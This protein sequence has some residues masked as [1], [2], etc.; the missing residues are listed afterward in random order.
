MAA[1]PNEHDLATAF[2]EQSLRA[3]TALFA[4]LYAL[5]T[6][7]GV[8]QVLN[9]TERGA[10]AVPLTVFLLSGA[11]AV[12]ARRDYVDLARL[13]FLSTLLLHLLVGNLISPMFQRLAFGFPLTILTVF[14]S[15]LTCP[16]WMAKRANLMAI[17]A[18]PVGYLLALAQGQDFGG[19]PAD[20]GAAIIGQTLIL[21]FSDFALARLSGGWTAALLDADIARSKIAAAHR[22]ALD[23]SRAKTTFLA[24]MSHELR[25]PLNAVIGYA[26]LVTDDLEDTGEADVRDLGRITVAARHL[27]ELVN[28]VLDLSR[29]EAGK[30]SLELKQ[31]D[32]SDLARQVCETLQPAVN[33]A[34]NRLVPRF[35]TVS[36]L[37]LDPLRTR[38]I[39][40]NLLGNATKFTKNGVIEVIVEER[41]GGVVV[42]VVDDG[43]GIPANRLE[44]VFRPF[45]QATET[46]QH[47]FGGTGLGLAISR[48]LAVEMGGTLTA[49]S[50]LGKG[51]RFTLWFPTEAPKKDPPSLTSD[52]IPCAL[53]RRAKVAA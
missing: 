3:T 42:E 12:G 22:I 14:L 29:I 6:V 24:S 5:G 31:S 23:G 18:L 33:G 37:L 49:A 8:L 41:S 1:D 28:Q 26:E 51:A 10:L 50:E 32:L 9:G 53:E 45:E 36:P 7:L 46:V 16:T 19:L 52:R 2:R 17:F 30:V 43:P 27:L 48:R 15:H 21:L 39:I 38:Q 13:V 44:E 34:R 25:T 40:T 47:K 11:A 4:G 20:V 35:G